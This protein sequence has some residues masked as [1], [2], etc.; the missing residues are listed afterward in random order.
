MATSPKPTT[1]YGDTAPPAPAPAPTPER[2]SAVAGNDNTNHHHQHHH[3]E[4][5]SLMSL[6]A[7]QI[8]ISPPR[9]PPYYTAQR[10]WMLGGGR[11]TPGR[12]MYVVVDRDY[13]DV[14]AT[15][16]KKNRRNTTIEEA[17]SAYDHHH[18][19]HAFLI[20][21]LLHHGN[22]PHIRNKKKKSN[23]SNNSD[24]YLRHHPHWTGSGGILSS[25]FPTVSRPSMGPLQLSDSL[26]RLLGT[27]LSLETQNRFRDTG[28]FRSVSD[29]LVTATIPIA[30]SVNP[31]ALLSFSKLTMSKRRLVYGT[32][33][34]TLQFIDVFF[35]PP[36]SSSSSS[37]T[38]GQS[39]RGMVIF[40][41]GGAW[42]SGK[43]WFYRLVALTFLRVGFAVAIIGYR[44]YP[45]GDVNVQVHD[46]GLAFDKLCVEYPDLM[47]KGCHIHGNDTNRNMGDNFQGTVLVGH[48]SG[49]HISLLWIVDRLK[50]IMKKGEDNSGIDQGVRIVDAF[51]GISGPYNVSH[52]FDYEAARGVEEISPLKAANGLTRDLLRKNSPANQLVSFLTDVDEGNN[53]TI[54]ERYFP[55]SLFIHGIEDETV[56]FTATSEACRVLRSCGLGNRCTE[57]YIPSTGHQDAVVHLMLGGKVQNAVQEWL[58]TDPT[59]KGHHHDVGNELQLRSKL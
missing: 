45:V 30:A 6:K 31:S 46:I 52:H 19:H 3:D 7:L 10:S 22:R 43:P 53:R 21:R 40:V 48:S 9:C 47:S 8:S 35:P 58:S 41:H 20:D 57:R 32:D 56:P 50:K 44:V 17:H 28:G 12:D 14:A 42:G 5:E 36:S 13:A 4:S 23:K 26:T 27:V 54:L 59:K 11:P 15:T 34:E 49:A 25:F 29:G 37:S 33:D 16:G 39:P 18:H 55:S 2:R 51:I 38:Q 1:H 24:N